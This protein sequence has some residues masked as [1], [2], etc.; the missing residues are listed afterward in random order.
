MIVKDL[1]R[2]LQLLPWHTKVKLQTPHNLFDSFHISHLEHRTQDVFLDDD[3]EECGP[4]KQNIVVLVG[5]VEEY[6]P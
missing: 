2:Q 5:Q 4:V 3:Y 6:T 1:V